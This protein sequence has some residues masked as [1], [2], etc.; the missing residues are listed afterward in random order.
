MKINFKD[1]STLTLVEAKKQVKDLTDSQLN[2]LIIKVNK[3][4]KILSDESDAR[5]EQTLIEDAEK[6]ADGELEN[7]PEP[8]DDEV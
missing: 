8:T 3:L 5:Y 2:N 6:E 1:I 7:L 4:V